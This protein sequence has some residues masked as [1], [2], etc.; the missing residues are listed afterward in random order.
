MSDF[1]THTIPTTNRLYSTIVIAIEFRS[2]KLR[3]EFHNVSGPV[4][5]VM[6]VA[7]IIK[8][9]ADHVLTPYAYANDLQMHGH[10]TS[11][12]SSE[13]MSYAVKYIEFVQAWM[14]SNR[15]H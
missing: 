5:F 1:S 11:V 6:H 2:S 4:L 13:L 8:L 14:A 9:T 3:S 12:Q 10:S 7:D 15:L